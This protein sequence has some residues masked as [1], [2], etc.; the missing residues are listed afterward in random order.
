MPFTEY[1]SDMVSAWNLEKKAY[2][3][4]LLDAFEYE[5]GFHAHEDLEDELPF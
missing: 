1:E 3:D 4:S 5:D 2:Q